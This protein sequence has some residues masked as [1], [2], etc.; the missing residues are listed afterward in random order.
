ML[1][2]AVKA[3]AVVAILAMAI[4]GMLDERLINLLFICNWSY[5]L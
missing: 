4:A 1:E 2:S 3:I 5:V